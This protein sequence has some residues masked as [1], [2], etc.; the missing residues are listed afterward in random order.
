[1]STRPANE[2]Y[3]IRAPGYLVFDAAFGYTAG[4]LKLSIVGENI[5]N[6]NWNEAQ[7]ATE[8]QLPG[9][10]L[11]VSELH[12]TPGSPLNVRAKVEVSF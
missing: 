1:M 6:T 11:P 5:F 10:T 12:F 2:D 9:E 3:S 4:S 8:S 7:F